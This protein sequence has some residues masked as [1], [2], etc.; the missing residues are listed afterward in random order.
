MEGGHALEDAAA[1]DVVITG[2]ADEQ[3]V[4]RTSS[5]SDGFLVLSDAYYPGWRATVDGAETPVYA[6]NYLLRGVY[7]PAGEHDGGL[8]LCAG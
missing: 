6:T 8:S 1:G 3:V 4:L 2:Y 5:P 7:V